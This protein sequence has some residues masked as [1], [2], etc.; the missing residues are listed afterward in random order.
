MTDPWDR[1]T[2]FCCDSCMFCVPKNE[3]QGRCRRHAPTMKGYPVIYLFKDW[4]GEHKIGSNPVR[5]A[6]ENRKATTTTGVNVEF[7]EAGEI[8]KQTPELN[9]PCPECLTCYHL[10]KKLDVEATEGEPCLRHTHTMDPDCTDCKKMIESMDLP[11][12]ILRIAI[13]SEA[14]P[15]EFATQDELKA[16]I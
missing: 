11:L 12:G 15:V 5:D 14:G 6:K 4:C 7:N 8:V 2:N 10:H 13:R 1:K 16:R 3:D 9:F